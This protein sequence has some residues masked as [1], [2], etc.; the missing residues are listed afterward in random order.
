MI[1]SRNPK[2]LIL[3]LP[4]SLQSPVK[5]KQLP[6]LKPNDLRAQ[7]FKGSSDPVKIL[8]AVDLEL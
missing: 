8:V 6:S 2:F 7:G 3:L 1:G 5:Q 4:F